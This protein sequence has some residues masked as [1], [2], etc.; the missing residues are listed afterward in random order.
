P[1]PSST[2]SRTVAAPSSTTTTST[3]RPAPT[4]LAAPRPP[5]TLSN[6]V[7]GPSTQAATMHSRGPSHSTP[8]SGTRTVGG[9]VPVPHKPIPAVVNKGYA[10]QVYGLEKGLEEWKLK[11]ITLECRRLT[12]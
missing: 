6:A 3:R 4:T 11:V 1:R 2:I 12:G 9:V 8:S 5:A 10:T 7:V